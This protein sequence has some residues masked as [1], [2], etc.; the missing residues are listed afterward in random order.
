MG[1]APDT[2][3][4]IPPRGSPSHLH[5]KPVDVLERAS[6]RRSYSTGPERFWPSSAR[7]SQ[8]PQQARKSGVSTTSRAWR[9]TGSRHS[10]VA[11]LAQLRFSAR[12][13]L[14]VVM[15]S[16]IVVR[17]GHLVAHLNDMCVLDDVVA[18]L[19]VCRVADPAPVAQVAEVAN[20]LDAFVEASPDKKA[21]SLRDVLYHVPSWRRR[22]AL[23]G[24]IEQR[25]H[26]APPPLRRGAPYARVAPRCGDR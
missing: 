5:R 4:G 22:Q 12:V 18:A 8:T 13:V 7:T 17:S 20:I 6:L 19:S 21:R 9:T 14:F 1:V 25:T 26:F 23:H 10:S 2:G 11:I 3:A 24:A 15:P 16:A